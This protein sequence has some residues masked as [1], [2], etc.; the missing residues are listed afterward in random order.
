[1]AMS[2]LNRRRLRNFRRNRAPS[3]RCSSFR[4]VRGGAFAELI[5]NDRPIV[6]ASGRAFPSPVYRFPETGFGGD[7][8]H[9]AIY[10]DPGVQCLIKTGGRPN[11]GTTGSGRERGRRDR[12][13]R[14]PS[15]RAGWMLWPPIP[16]HYRT[17]NNVGTAPA[18]RTASTS[19]APTTPRAMCWRG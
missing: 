14:G 12:H 10:T 15:G 11:A 13:G 4:A 17:I 18:R 8:R 2:E 6:V 19:W 16:Y 5:A 7:F 3:G 9:R 1:M